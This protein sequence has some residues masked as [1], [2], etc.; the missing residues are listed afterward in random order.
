MGFL[1]LFSPRTRGL[2]LLISSSI[3]I[4]I[5]SM[6]RDGA[7]EDNYGVAFIPLYVFLFLALLD[8]ASRSSPSDTLVE[9]LP[10][11]V[12][13][14][15]LHESCVRT[16]TY[17]VWIIILVLTPLYLEGL[18]T[19]PLLSIGCLLSTW[20]LL[21]AFAQY[22]GPTSVLR[23]LTLHA[24]AD[25]LSDSPPVPVV[26]I[27]SGGDHTP[28]S[29]PFEDAEDILDQKQ[30]TVREMSVRE[31]LRGSPLRIESDYDNLPNGGSDDEEGVLV[32][33]DH[34]NSR[35]T[36]VIQQR[37]DADVSSMGGGNIS[38]SAVAQGLR[39]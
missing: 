17:F 22:L 19:V 23:P 1:Q 36:V 4:F 9:V 30:G 34:Y 35:H 38:P 13:R 6:M 27:D 7:F 12:T 21:V 32:D 37:N 26:G 25:Y 16:L 29:T 14:R 24:I 33:N 39:N 5:V 15:A 3:T 20:L 18:K 8:V 2:F 10:G 28:V 31:S 11:G